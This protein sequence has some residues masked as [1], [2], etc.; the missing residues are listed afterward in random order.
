M[1]EIQLVLPIPK[2]RGKERGCNQKA[3]TGEKKREGRKYCTVQGWFPHL[4]QRNKASRRGS[5]FICVI[6]AHCEKEGI[7]FSVEIST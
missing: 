5:V 1:A 4:Y 6:T 7:L 3:A 2:R